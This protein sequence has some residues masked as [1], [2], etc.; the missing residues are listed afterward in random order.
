MAYVLP[1]G[2]VGGGYSLL[3]VMDTVCCC[4]LILLSLLRLLFLFVCLFLKGCYPHAN[5]FGQLCGFQKFN[6]VHGR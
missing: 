1:I 3:M 2:F 5:L 4:K 6:S